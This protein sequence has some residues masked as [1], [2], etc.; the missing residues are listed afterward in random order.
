MPPRPM[1]IGS[2]SSKTP[3]HERHDVVI[4]DPNGPEQRIS[5]FCDATRVAHVIWQTKPV[6][7]PHGQWINMLGN[8]PY[9]AF[10][11]G[12]MGQPQVPQVVNLVLGA[13]GQH[14]VFV[15]N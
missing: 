12:I 9:L 3:T 13:G 5:I 4:E 7:G 15:A 8:P 1:W 10:D 11:R 14:N 2:A 6:P